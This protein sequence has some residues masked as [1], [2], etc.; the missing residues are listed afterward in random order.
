M[1]GNV[2]I[3]RMGKQLPHDADVRV[4]VYRLKLRCRTVDV[5]RVH[6]LRIA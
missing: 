4:P 6:P 3:G 2:G 5:L 1:N